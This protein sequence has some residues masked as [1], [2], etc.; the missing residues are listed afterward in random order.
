MPYLRASGF[1]YRP[2]FD[3]RDPELRKTLSLGIW[4]VLFVIV[5]QAAYFV[6][7]ASP[8]AAR[9]TAATAPATPSTP[10]ACSS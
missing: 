2:R 10:A 4:T 6:V 9:P 1:T 7:V 8:P 3:F 5:T